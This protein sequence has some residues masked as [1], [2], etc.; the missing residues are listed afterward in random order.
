MWC[1]LKYV[2]HIL[3][4]S[5]TWSPYISN[6]PNLVLLMFISD[7]IYLNVFR[8]LNIDDTASCEKID[9]VKKI[10]TWYIANYNAIILLTVLIMLNIMLFFESN[11]ERYNCLKLSNNRSH[12]T[13]HTCIMIIVHILTMVYIFKLSWYVKCVLVTSCCTQRRV[14]PL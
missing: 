8:S 9:N 10:S 6:I 11:S 7:K 4:D 2:W 3:Y 5:Q 12:L 13:F 14:Q 1:H